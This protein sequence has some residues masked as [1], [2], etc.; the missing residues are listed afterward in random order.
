MLLPLGN[1]KG[2]EMV[3]VLVLFWLGIGIG[4][5]LAYMESWG[6]PLPELGRDFL[7]M[8]HLK[9]TGKEAFVSEFDAWEIP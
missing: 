4:T 1:A 7:F 5:K 8:A 9:G 2:K 3:L 6:P